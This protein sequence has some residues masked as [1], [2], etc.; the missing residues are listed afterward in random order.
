MRLRIVRRLFNPILVLHLV[1]LHNYSTISMCERI[2]IC[3]IKYLLVILWIKIFR[4]FVGNNRI[5]TLTLIG[6]LHRKNII[7]NE[8]VI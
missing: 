8:T 1:L 2:L 7:N 5:I 3:I 4:S 6:H